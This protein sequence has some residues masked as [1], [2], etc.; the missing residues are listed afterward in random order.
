MKD[1]VINAMWFY[2]L[3]LIIILIVL[4]FYE[5]S[6]IANDDVEALRLLKGAALLPGINTLIAFIIVGLLL[7]ATFAYILYFLGGYL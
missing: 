2:F 6:F 5:A 7:L 3:P 1:N 4:H